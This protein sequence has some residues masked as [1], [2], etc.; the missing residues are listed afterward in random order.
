[1]DSNTTNLVQPSG[2]KNY[3]DISNLISFSIL[4]IDDSHSLFFFSKFKIDRI[5]IV[6]HIFQ[7]WFTFQIYNFTV[8]KILEERKEENT[9][10][11][12]W[13]EYI[14]ISFS[15]LHLFKARRRNLKTTKSSTRL[16][17]SAIRIDGKRT[18][19]S[20]GW[21]ANLTF[22]VQRDTLVFLLDEEVT[23]LI[24]LLLRNK[25]YHERL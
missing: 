13:N 25:L 21:L 16:F 3:L 17:L 19:N 12:L 14:K 9:A 6:W 2:F 10:Q 1:M 11:I 22:K 23:L 7:H 18:R 8:E 4:R 20:Q 15:G 24:I 5:V